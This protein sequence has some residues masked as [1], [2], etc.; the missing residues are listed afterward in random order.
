MNFKKFSY[1]KISSYI[2][3]SNLFNLLK[4]FISP[5]R[6]FLSFLG[7]SGIYTF[8]NK[9][10]SEELSQI[11]FE[12]R[13]YKDENFT[14]MYQN[15]ADSEDILLIITQLNVC[16]ENLK[17]KLN[18]LNNKQMIDFNHEY[19]LN[20]NISLQNKT[21]YRNF[22][23]YQKSLSFF[24]KMN[25]IYKNFKISTQITKKIK[26]IK[27]ECKKIEFLLRNFC[28]LL[29]DVLFSLD[30]KDNLKNKLNSLNNEKIYKI[31]ANEIINI[32][33]EIENIKNN[34]IFGN[35]NIDE[36]KNF[37]SKDEKLIFYNYIF[38][39]LEEITL[40]LLSNFAIFKQ[41]NLVNFQFNKGNQDFCI[42]FCEKII[43]ENKLIKNETL[44]YY[45]KN[46]LINYLAISDSPF[47]YS[48]CILEIN[49]NKNFYDLKDIN[50]EKAENKYSLRKTKH[51]H[52]EFE[53]NQN[54]HEDLHEKEIHK[55]YKNFDY[56]I[57]FVCGLNANFAK[58]W[59]IPDEVSSSDK[60]DIM[61]FYLKGKNLE[62]VFPTQNFKLWITKMMESNTFKNH[63]IRYIVSVGETKFF[64]LEHMMNNIPD[65]TINEISE[66][67]YK[68]LKFVNVGK[69]PFILICH[70]MGG[71]IA[72]NMIK[73]AD[74]NKDT[75]FIKN[76]KGI[77]FFSTPHLG[78]NIINS[79]I[80]SAVNKYIKFLYI[81]NH[82][83][84]DH[85]FENHDL[86]QKISE[87]QFAKAC[88]EIC[89]S[90]KEIFEKQHQEFKNFKINYINFVETDKT[91]IKQ[92]G[93]KVHI[94]QPESAYLPETLNFIL[95]NKMHNNLQKF[96]P[97]NYNEKGYIIL[98]NYIKDRFELTQ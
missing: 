68:S 76:N 85:G 69:K 3:N 94:V 90:E 28:N 97:D 53:K 44:L 34:S 22:T 78:S 77:V 66:R 45:A 33:K 14:K 58:S 5:K 29:D 80:S 95:D 32:L 20:H 87:F 35:L 48:D 38:N 64:R 39:D 91:F 37:R 8:I 47:F 4:S 71:L 25:K 15:K 98:C 83:V 86:H 1:L 73:I 36:D 10:Q 41:F 51:H 56:D 63:N 84:T 24:E 74:E 30:E 89:F 43:E 21:N 54:H 81:I 82:T 13:L 62:K 92:I 26:G 72:K 50:L 55:I 9:N 49:K 79:I 75:D 67:I 42:K 96:T 19:E 12:K 88:T 6:I 16:I 11:D 61:Y 17:K 27:K 93:E 59:R 60:K 40:R 2:K 46:F 7:V 65:L 23:L 31:N 52:E 70:S 18:M 57:I